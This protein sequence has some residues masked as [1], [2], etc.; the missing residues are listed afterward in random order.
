MTENTA[1]VP[2]I[3]ESDE[4]DKPK[5]VLVPTK[6]TEGRD[7]LNFAEF[8]LSALSEKSDPSVKTI[9]FE[10]KIFDRSKNE[11][12]PR[13]VTITGSDAFGLPTPLDEEV[14]LALIQ[15]SK[16]QGFT[17]KRVYFTR[18]QLLQILNWAPNGQCYSRLDQALNR[19][20]GVTMYYKNAWRDRKAQSWVDESFHMLERVKIIT[21]ERRSA[22]SGYTSYF[23][24]NEAVFKSFQNGNVKALN[25]DFFL[26]I[27][28]SIA[29]RL[30]RFLDKRFHHS[31]SVEFELKSLCYEHVG[32]SRN[33]P[34]ADLKR[35][36]SRAIDELESRGF[37]APISKEDRFRKDAPGLWKVIFK[38][39]V[40]GDPKSLESKAPPKVK[41]V[42]EMLVDFGIREAKAAEL[43]KLHGEEVVRDKLTVA[44]WLKEKRDQSLIANPPGFLIASIEKDFE[45]PKAF[46]DEILKA[47]RT[48]A[49]EEASRKGKA[50][51]V[52]RQEKEELDA[53]RKSRLVE[54]YLL[55]LTGAERDALIEQAICSADKAK[56]RL[57]T[58]GGRVA[59]ALRT[60]IVES[61]V[62][63]L[64]AEG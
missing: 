9:Y 18:Y 31:I 15:L 5:L 58:L 45:T 42:E 27:E 47:E 8:P 37:L 59:E 25:Y 22:D 30:Y 61:Y 41:S 19:W 43:V 1:L 39:A 29:K 54:D 4:H 20:M 11:F 36:L 34:V 51:E 52:K 64:L 23:E 13:R 40:Q 53:Q 63:E 12:I 33:S 28:S 24:W 57:L 16:L 14:L 60:V 35:K 49:S 50:A 7:E 26:S 56:Q 55:G 38:K 6:I 44:T 46:S 2:E 21:D 62:L 17:S 10:D 48:R 32:L 3:V